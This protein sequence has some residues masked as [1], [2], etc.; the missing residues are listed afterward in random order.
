MAPATI[1]FPG[2]LHALPAAEFRPRVLLPLSPESIKPA[3]SSLP[4]L[5]E[6]CLS[7]FHSSSSLHS[8]FGSVHI[9]QPSCSLP[10]TQFPPR[11]KLRAR[12]SCDFISAPIRSCLSSQC[13]F[14]PPPLFLPFPFPSNSPKIYLQSNPPSPPPP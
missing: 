3:K 8:L 1:G 13:L 2:A 9:P 10:F 14:Y 5:C 4:L 12:P 11:P 7:A 6:L